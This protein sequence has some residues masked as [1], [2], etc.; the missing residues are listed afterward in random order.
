MDGAMV[1]AEFAG[2]TRVIRK[3]G[4]CARSF[5]WH[6]TGGCSALHLWMF[7]TSPGDASSAPPS[8]AHVRASSKARRKRISW[9]LAAPALPAFRP[10]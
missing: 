9:G 4:P 5:V 2:T 10:P 6:V 1:A 8:R 3:G 7:R